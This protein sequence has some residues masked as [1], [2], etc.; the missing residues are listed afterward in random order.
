M[1]A[2][3][4][5]LRE[6]VLKAL[7]NEQSAEQV[8]IRFDVSMSWVYKIKKRFQDTGSYEALRR[9][10]RPKKLSEEDVNKIS[11]MLKANP[12]LT[13]DEI[14]E[15]VKFKASCTTIYR[16]LQRLKL[17]YKKNTFCGRAKA[18]RCKAKKN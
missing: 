5:D 14:K 2:Y 6:K 4:N 7:H 18:N 3:S 15:K 9:S 11:D 12:S 8:A 13:L 16:A 17:T 10:G 1:R